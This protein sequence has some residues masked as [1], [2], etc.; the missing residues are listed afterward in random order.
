M[1]VAY[2]IEVQSHDDPYIQVAE[3]V[4][5]TIAE[6]TDAGSYLAKLVCRFINVYTHLRAVLLQ[7]QGEEETSKTGPSGIMQLD[8]KCIRRAIDVHNGYMEL[9]GV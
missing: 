2:D 7:R 6:T 9:R 4:A 1:A 8:M 3:D 5:A